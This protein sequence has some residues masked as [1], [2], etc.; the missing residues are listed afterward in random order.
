MLSARKLTHGR[1]KLFA[2]RERESAPVQET[3][4]LEISLQDQTQT[5]NQF[6]FCLLICHAQLV[7]MQQYG[8]LDNS[9]SMVVGRSP[10]LM[11]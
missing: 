10:Y 4:Q 1:T 8:F 6:F 7:M 2:E 5:L 9:F 3:R 11:S